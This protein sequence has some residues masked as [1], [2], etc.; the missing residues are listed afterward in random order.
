VVITEEMCRHFIG[1]FLVTKKLGSAIH[2]K[3]KK[4]KGNK[5]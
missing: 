4:K 3:K 5:K 1:E 2:N